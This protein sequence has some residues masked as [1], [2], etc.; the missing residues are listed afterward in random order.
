M[1]AGDKAIY[2]RGV[3][4]VACTVGVIAI[5]SPAVRLPLAL[6]LACYLPGS[7]IMGTAFRSPRSTLTALIFSVGLSITTTIFC[8]FA[9]HF[10]GAMTRVGWAITLCLVTLA[11]LGGA[12][13]RRSRW[14]ENDA[15]SS[16]R[17]RP[18]QAAMMLAAAGLALA[19]VVIER[20]QTFA[21]SEFTYTEFW[22][23]PQPDSGVVVLG[24]KNEE[25]TSA[26]YDVEVSID[27][28]IAHVWRG[29][30][31]ATGETWQA[32]FTMPARAASSNGVE[33]KLFKNSDRSVIYRR[34]WL[35]SPAAG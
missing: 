9:L 32:E 28:S 10:V 15:H 8:G 33:A 24:V 3:T 31:L 12:R 34:V 35:P 1:R 7:A 26:T 11:A 29:V 13:L 14:F 20:Q 16:P 22:M 6:L 4:A 18:L 30:N 23:V 25:T 27:D 17:L 21:R 19:A 2:L 5:S